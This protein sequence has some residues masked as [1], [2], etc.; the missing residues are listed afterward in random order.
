MTTRGDKG[1]Q[2]PF[3]ESYAIGL[4]R[5]SKWAFDVIVPAVVTAFVLSKVFNSMPRGDSPEVKQ[6]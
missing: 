6:R 5:A 4:A 3:F 2:R 1:G